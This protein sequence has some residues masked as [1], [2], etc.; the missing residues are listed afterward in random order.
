MRVAGL[1]RP[2]MLEQ[3]FRMG[4][5][6][7]LEQFKDA[8]RMMAVPMWNA[9]YA[10]AD[11]HIMLVFDGLVPKRNFEDFPYWAKVVPGDTSKTLWTEYHSFED[12]PKSIDP[13]S[14]FNQNT[15]EPPWTSTLP[16]IGSAPSSRLTCRKR[17]SSCRQ[18][19]TL[20]SLRMLTKMD[21]I[22]Y[23]QMLADKFSTE[24][25]LA[26]A[27]VPD[28]LKAANDST[29]PAILEAAQILGA[30]DHRAEADSR[31]RSAVSGVC[32]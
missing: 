2:K 23:D 32:G 31:G 29:D 8:L 19:R 26:D 20:R 21:K 4:E 10:D 14:G 9:N 11:G 30:W 1:D 16:R 5:A 12:L 15:N 22:T 7:N 18:F 13:P 3:W 25:G 24:M 6:Q 27:V 17:D 28:L